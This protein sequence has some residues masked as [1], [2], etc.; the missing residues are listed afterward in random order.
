MSLLKRHVFH[1]LPVETYA[2]S[3]VD[4]L[5][6]C[7]RKSEADYSI[8]RNYLN[9]SEVKLNALH[10]IFKAT[11]NICCFSYETKHVDIQ[12]GNDM[13]PYEE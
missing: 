8:L 9:I 3:G 4:G 1:S 7:G 5:F 6:C 12:T 2:P 11:V 13:S 10:I